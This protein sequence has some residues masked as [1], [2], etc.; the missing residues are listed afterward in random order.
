M[1]I[2]PK[3]WCLRAKSKVNESEYHPCCLI[4]SKCL[5]FRSWMLSLMWFA[6]LLAIALTIS[7][8]TYFKPVYEVFG[9]QL[10]PVIG[11]LLVSAVLLCL[12][13]SAAGHIAQWR[14]IKQVVRSRGQ[15]CVFCFYDLSGR[16]RD[17]DICPECGVVA[18]RRECVR[19]WCKL[20]RSRF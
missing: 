16:P 6:V 13:Q 20:L 4:S 19:L 3:P 18:P 14:S 9:E 11:S 2:E 17:V 15:M 7:V 10:Y 1:F 12:I 8:L 5:R